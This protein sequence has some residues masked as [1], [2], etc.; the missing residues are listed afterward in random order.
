VQSS[1]RVKCAAM[2][3]P[4]LLSLISAAAFSTP[5]FPAQE[6]ETPASE[7]MLR[8]LDALSEALGAA[9]GE[10]GYFGSEREGAPQDADP[11]PPDAFRRLDDLLPTPNRTRTASGAPGPDYWQQKV[12]YR[13]RARLDE[14]THEIEGVEEIRYHNRSPDTLEYLWVQLDDNWLAP[15]S[16]DV[17]ATTVADLGGTEVWSLTGWLARQQFDGSVQ[18]R[19]ASAGDRPLATMVN[20][21]MMRV[22]LPQPLAP[23][24]TF[25]FR[26]AWSLRLNPAGLAGSRA[27]VEEFGDDSPIFEAAHWYPRL[28]A[29]D[30]VEGWQ[31]KQFQGNGEFALEFGDFEVELTVPDD[32]IVAATG[33][34]QNPGE[35][36]TEEQRARWAQAMTPGNDGPVLI[37]TAEDAATNLI[38]PAEGERTWRFAAQNVR[39]FAWAS[40]RRFLWD[41]WGVQTRPDGPVIAAQSFWPPE[42][43]P[44]WTEFSTRAVAHALQ[45][46][47]RFTFDYPYPS[48]ASVNGPVYGMEYPMICFNAPRP[49]P[50]NEEREDEWS[51]VGVV[52]HEVGH[53]FFPMIVNSDERQWTWMDEGLNSFVESHAEREW[54]PDF[55]LYTGDNGMIAVNM[56]QPE[57]QP[58]MTSSDGTVNFGW[59]G[60]GKPSAGLHLL[61]DVVMG[62]ELFD[63]AFRTYARRWMFRRPQPADFFRSI[64]DASAV[65]LDWFWRAWFFETASVDLAVE[66]VRT[67]PGET[68]EEAGAPIGTHGCAVSVVN[69]GG[70]IAPLLFRLVFEDGETEERAIPVEVWR[71]DPRRVEVVLL[72]SRPVTGVFLDPDQRT[73][74]TY[75]FDNSADPDAE[76][77]EHGQ[78]TDSIVEILQG[79][80][81]DGGSDFEIPYEDEQ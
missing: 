23:G 78:A 46:Y 28:C 69:S 6:P 39:D 12:D 58:I 59:N 44:L 64:E 32:H 76:P 51:L 53:N 31:H 1:L 45:V 24:A 15:D 29:Y 14:F 66:S 25:E 79:L 17:R 71:R 42:G 73:Y 7:E 22:D 20:G 9:D 50:W 41:C 35:V 70:M 3:S 54:S 49:S 48:A 56:A 30:D 34:L 52:I 55:P 80:N 5:I 62:P 2:P 65:D 21:T 37:V 47:S 60:Y 40:S 72:T 74:D 19:E 68:L 11:R 38:L 33:M 26:I 63:A 61:R 43:D 16:L 77:P 36:L 4:A 27:G 67:I 18:I 10:S 75:P 57:A 8:Q 13:I 81:F